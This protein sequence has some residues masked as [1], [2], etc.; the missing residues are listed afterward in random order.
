M[1]K[2]RIGKYT[3]AALISANKL[4]NPEA[5]AAPVIHGSGKT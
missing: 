1:Y 4:Y 5:T 2:T 3:S